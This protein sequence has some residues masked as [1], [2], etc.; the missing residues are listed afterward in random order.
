M[1]DEGRDRDSVGPLTVSQGMN[2]MTPQ[3]LQDLAE[4]ALTENLKGF[5]SLGDAEYQVAPLGHGRWR[6]ES[7]WLSS[8]T[9]VVRVH[10]LEEQ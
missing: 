7:S 4:R 9:F 5:V 1:V 6:V 10:V 3:A 8:K 2:H